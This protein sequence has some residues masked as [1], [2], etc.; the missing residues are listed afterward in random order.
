MRIHKEGYNILITVM[1]FFIVANT[2]IFIFLASWKGFAVYFLIFSIIIYFL[3]LW[4]FRLPPRSVKQNDNLII[5]PADGRIV[6]IEETLENE[7]FN[8]KRLQV[9]IFMSPLNVHVNLFPI[10]GLVKYFKYHPGKYLVAWHPK[11]SE[12]NEHSS[13]VVENGK[14]TLLVRQIAGVLARRIV[15]YAR[16]GEQV[17]QGQEL[18]FIKFGSRVDLF[19]PPDVKLNVKLDQ[20]VFGKKTIIAFFD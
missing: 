6:K 12:K 1:V 14:H 11:A 19:L 17:Q 20:K 5:S 16:S 10:A 13:V 9:S 3:M 7:Y 2:L 15:C 8:D 18:G 4:F